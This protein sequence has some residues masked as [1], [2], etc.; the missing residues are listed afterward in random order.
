MSLMQKYTVWFAPHERSD[1][2]TLQ[3]FQQVAGD[4][5]MEPVGRCPHPQDGKPMW[6]AVYKGTDQLMHVLN[7]WII[8]GWRFDIYRD[9]RHPLTK[10]ETRS[11]FNRRANARVQSYALN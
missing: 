8:D 5:D 11:W 6:K 7:A 9:D 3:E 1:L 2:K 10:R 4:F